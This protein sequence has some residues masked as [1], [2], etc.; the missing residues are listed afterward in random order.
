MPNKYKPL[1]I[2]LLISTCALFLILHRGAYQGFFTDDEL[3]SLSWAPY[4]KPA[5]FLKG[6]VDPRFQPDNF[7]P[8]GHFYF[9]EMGRH[10]QWNYTAYPVPIHVIHLLN[11][12][13]IFGIARRLKI[14]PLPATAG[15]AF[16]GLNMAAFDVFWKP[17]YVFDAL[18]CFFSLLCLWCYMA[19]RWIVSLI[20]FWLAYKSKELAVMLPAVLI[21]YEYWF[22]ERRWK[23]LIPFVIISLSF[24]IQGI[25]MNPNRNNDYTFRFSIDSLRKTIPFYSERFLFFRYSGLTLLAFPLLLSRDRRVAFGIAAMCLFLFPLLFLPGRLFEAYTY[26]PL[27]GAALAFAAV[28]A[29]VHPA[30]T[31]AFFALWLPLGIHELRIERRTKLA[32]DQEAQPYFAAI[33]AYANSH[34]AP[35]AF[36]YDGRPIGMQPWG[37]TGGVNMAWSRLHMQTHYIDEADNSKSMQLPTVAFLHWDAPHKVV[38]FLTKSPDTWTESFATA[39]LFRPAG[40]TAFEIVANVDPEIIH[41]FGSTT[42]SVG[43][44]GNPAGIATFR[45]KGDQSAKILLTPAPAGEAEITFTT[46]PVAQVGNIVSF[47]FKYH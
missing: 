15:A 39:K 27:T 12:V 4:L 34:P 36:I 46:S 6:L 37:V 18:C 24:G 44:N 10:F 1:A 28:C 31:V 38:Q 26:L 3:E 25:L 47:A 7:R 35:D 11:V 30:I 42:V 13:L 19:N 14:P 43:I 17:M 16:F 22:G 20:A 5:L 2:A 33:R 23:R 29:Q 32:A 40:A 41:R 45:D 21:L 8:V 9:S